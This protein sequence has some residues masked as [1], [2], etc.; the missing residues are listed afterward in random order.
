[1]GLPLSARMGGQESLLGG[2][3]TRQENPEVRAKH[4]QKEGAVL[5][6]M[7]PPI[8]ILSS[9]RFSRHKRTEGRP[10]TRPWEM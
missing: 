2:S 3:A 6:K 5:M 4:E 9:F 7:S 1:M 8:S 10:V